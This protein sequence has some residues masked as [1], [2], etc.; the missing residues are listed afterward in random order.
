MKFRVQY[1]VTVALYLPEKLRLS[2]HQPCDSLFKVNWKVGKETQCV[3]SNQN[4]NTTTK[5]TKQLHSKV[6]NFQKPG[7]ALLTLSARLT[8]MWVQKL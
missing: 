2:A 1:T 4:N 8:G 5:Q 7:T 6:F 3:L